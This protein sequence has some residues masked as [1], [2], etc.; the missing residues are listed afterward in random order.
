VTPPTPSGFWLATQAKEGP[1]STD[2]DTPSIHLLKPILYSFHSGGMPVIKV[3]STGRGLLCRYVYM[4]RLYKWW[5]ASPRRSCVS[6][7]LLCFIILVSPHALYVCDLMLQYRCSH[8]FGA[9]TQLYV[10]RP[11]NFPGVGKVQVPPEKTPR[12]L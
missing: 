6:S 2:K 5:H 8:L 9:S 10:K 12:I 4:L 11:R 1:P 7:S 3:V